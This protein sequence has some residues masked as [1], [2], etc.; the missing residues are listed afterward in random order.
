MTLDMAP[1]ESQKAIRE[2]GRP[3]YDALSAG[4]PTAPPLDAK[5]LVAAFDRWDREVGGQKVK[6]S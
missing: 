4:H 2:Y 1:P 6:K 3:E 5:A